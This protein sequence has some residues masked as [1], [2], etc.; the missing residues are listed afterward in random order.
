MRR[1]LLTIVC[2]ALFVLAPYVAAAQSP[3]ETDGAWLVS[4]HLAL[5][6]D[7][8]ADPSLAFGAGLAYP[9]TSALAI[10][11]ELSHALDLVPG[12]ADVDSSLTTVHGSLLYFFRTSYRLT[13]YVAGGLGFGKFSHDV[14]APPASIDRTEV[15]FNLGGGVTYPVNSALWLRGDFRVLK[16]IDDVPTIWRFGGGITIAIGD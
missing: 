6:L 14:T 7:D 1:S 15:G 11:G 16:H 3:V 8:D 2:S 5:V 9:L 4:P 13:P 10:E 12:D